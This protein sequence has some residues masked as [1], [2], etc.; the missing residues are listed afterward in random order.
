M[1]GQKISGHVMAAEQADCERDFSSYAWIFRFSLPNRL[2]VARQAN[3]C[4][5]LQVSAL[6]KLLQSLVKGA[7]LVF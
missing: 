7:Q 3:N 6:A 4:Q 1:K 5:M 2:D